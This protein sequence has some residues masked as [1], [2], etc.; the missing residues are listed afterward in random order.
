VYDV[1]S[2]QV[3]SRLDTPQVFGKSGVWRYTS[4]LMLICY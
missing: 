4:F 3:H 2:I 1:E